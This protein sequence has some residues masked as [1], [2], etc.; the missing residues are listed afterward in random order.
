MKN[1]NTKYRYYVH[2]E[3]NHLVVRIKENV[4]EWKVVGGWIRCSFRWWN[5]VRNFYKRV[6]EEEFV[7]FI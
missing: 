1:K 2:K 4:T 5:K 7:L 3:N 6:K